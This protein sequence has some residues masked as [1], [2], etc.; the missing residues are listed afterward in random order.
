MYPHLIIEENEVTQNEQGNIPLGADG[1][2]GQQENA[3]GEGEEDPD[4]VGVN[5]IEIGIDS[6]ADGDDKFDKE[7]NK[8]KKGCTIF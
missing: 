2:E 1:E 7:L 6:D 3:E 5:R 4:A 8:K